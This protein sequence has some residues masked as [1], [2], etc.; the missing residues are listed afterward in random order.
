VKKPECPERA[1]ESALRRAGINGYVVLG[2]DQRRPLVRTGFFTFR[3]GL[4]FGLFK[5]GSA[6]PRSGS[7]CHEVAYER[8]P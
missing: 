5:S 1:R 3:V 2:A 6:D 8:T 4:H 7:E